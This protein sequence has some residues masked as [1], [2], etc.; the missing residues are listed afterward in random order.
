MFFFLHYRNRRNDNAGDKPLLVVVG[1]I[2]VQGTIQFCLCLI[3]IMYLILILY[4][5]FFFFLFSS[6]FPSIF[7]LF[8]PCF[9]FFLHLKE[10]RRHQHLGH[11]SPALWNLKRQQK[12]EQLER[13][14]GKIEGKEEGE[15]KEKGRRKEGE[16]KE[17]GRV[18]LRGTVWIL[19]LLIPLIVFTSIFFANQTFAHCT[20]YDTFHYLFFE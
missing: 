15:R 18:L 8:V 9:D 7:F 19:A 10:D 17:E 14:V 3:S 2:S 1:F 12:N 11:Y 5:C 20:F 16:R 6:S 13:I 4:K